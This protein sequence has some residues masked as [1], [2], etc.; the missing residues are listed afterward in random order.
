MP[1]EPTTG[2]TPGAGATPAQAGQPTTTPPAAQGA[3]PPAATTAPAAA[4]SPAT[5]DEAAL[6]DAGKRILAEARRREREAEARAKAAEQE[7]DALREA[8]QTE[9][10]KAIAAARKE[11]EATVRAAFEAR[12]RRSEIRTALT[13]AGITASE[14]D[15]ASLA[16]EFAALVVTDDGVDGL[17]QAVAAFRTAHPTLFAPARPAVVG[18]ADGGARGAASVDTQIKAAQAEGDFRTA[19]HLKNRQLREAAARKG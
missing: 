19:I 17:A 11:G 1:D 13:A 18:S 10:E 3:T 12:I 15:L 9:T 4:Q 16:P 5:D 14:L 7:R 2:A 6:G 8:T